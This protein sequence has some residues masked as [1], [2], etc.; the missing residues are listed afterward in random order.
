VKTFTY[1]EIIDILE[2]IADDENE[3]C[4]RFYALNP[5]S[6]GKRKSDSIMIN[7]MICKIMDKFYDRYYLK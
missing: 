3:N 2:K 6:D 1:L 7:S 4:K 5:D